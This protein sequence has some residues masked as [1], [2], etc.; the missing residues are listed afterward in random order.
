V[1]DDQHVADLK[2]RG[3]EVSADGKITITLQGDFNADVLLTPTSAASPDI[4]NT[5][6]QFARRDA[7][8]RY[9]WTQRG[10]INRL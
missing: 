4:V 6:S 8:G 9:R 3:G 2:A 5:L 7:Q 1:A 10:N